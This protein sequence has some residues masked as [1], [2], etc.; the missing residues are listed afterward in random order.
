M[1]KNPPPL[2][3][4]VT[5]SK[6]TQAIA[7]A[8]SRLQSELSPKLTYHN[9]WHTKEDVL[10]GCRR[11]ADLMDI[12]GED[13]I[14]LEVS[15]AYH[16]IGFVKSSRDHEL[17]GMNIAA[18]ILPTFGFSEREIASVSKMI[19]ATRLPQAPQNV[20]GEILADADLDVLGRPDFFARN[21]C[22]RQE[23]ANFGKESDTKKWYEDQLLFLEKHV[24][25]TPAA[26]SL[27]DAGKLQ[28]IA[29]IN[30]K[31]QALD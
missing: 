25:F 11:L 6:H 10:P 3:S 17:I 26:R 7:Y 14:L 1:L 31:L 23:W 24:Y 2:V 22:L 30:E 5:L 18:E 12:A 16:D 21:A 4:I 28:N 29:M 20:L 13:R 8:F 19:L 27:R 9:V 15:A